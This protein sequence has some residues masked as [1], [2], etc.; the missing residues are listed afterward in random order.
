[1]RIVKERFSE[2]IK[3]A[4]CRSW[5]LSPNVSQCLNPDS[6]IIAFENVF[7]RYPIQSTGKEL[8]AFLFR[9]SPDNYEDLPEETSLQRKIKRIYL[10]GGYIYAGAGVI[11]DEE[12]YK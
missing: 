10:D 3:F 6:K 8:M 4:F 7:H 5:L 12:F 9:M 1:M 2:K 11:T